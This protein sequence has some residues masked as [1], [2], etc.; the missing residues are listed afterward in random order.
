[1]NSDLEK[2]NDVGDRAKNNFE[3]NSRV[4]LKQRNTR[5]IKNY[6]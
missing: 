4:V 1:M 2:N 5:F 6:I 3:R